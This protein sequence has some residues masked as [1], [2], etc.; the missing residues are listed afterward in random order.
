[1]KLALDPKKL[2]VT[3]VVG[4]SLLAGVAVGAAVT[5]AT[6][7]ASAASPSPLDSSFNVMQGPPPP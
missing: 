7:A 4:G 5:L 2:L 1:M 3:G 6:T